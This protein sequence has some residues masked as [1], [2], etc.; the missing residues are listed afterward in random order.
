MKIAT[1]SGNTNAC[2]KATNNH[3]AYNNNGHITGNPLANIQ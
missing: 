2:I 1:K 3:C